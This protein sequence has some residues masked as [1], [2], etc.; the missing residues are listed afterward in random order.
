MPD[1]S[2]F[3]VPARLELDAMTADIPV[4]VLTSKRLSRAGQREPAH[5]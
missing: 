5:G 4:V 1:M 3:E 2:G